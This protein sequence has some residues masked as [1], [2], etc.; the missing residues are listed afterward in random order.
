MRS[1]LIWMSAAALGGALAGCGS[2]SGNSVVTTFGAS[3]PT[4]PKLQGQVR[5]YMTR[6]G[7]VPESLGVEMN[8][9]AL[10][11]FTLPVPPNLA[12]EISMPAPVGMASLT[13]FQSVSI[14]LAQP[15]PPAGNQDVPHVH[16]NWYIFTP[17][18]RLAIPPTPEPGSDAI[19]PDEVAPG[20][21]VFPPGYIPTI[22]HL[23]INPNIQGYAERPFTTT[24]YE[25]RYYFGRMTLIALGIADSFLASKQAK[26][27]IIPTPAKY[28]KP[29]YYPTRYHVEF[30]SARRV[31]NMAMDGF[32]LR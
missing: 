22:G 5:A 9:V 26:S 20:D 21:V 28:R 24:E 23:V 18:E 16:P 29:G 6:R 32:V 4:G 3:A 25:Y 19:P 12:A 17:T 14:F 30:D 8:E 13:P 10:G 31:W 1:V 7:N 2:D 11:D 15:H 27:D